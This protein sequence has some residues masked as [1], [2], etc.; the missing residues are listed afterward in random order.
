VKELH[1]SRA[2]CRWKELPWSP[3]HFFNGIDPADIAAPDP[4]WN[5]PTQLALIRGQKYIGDYLCEDV[6]TTWVLIPR[7][8]FF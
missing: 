5:L 3:E 6:V 2:S 8:K 7:G 4:K 1:I